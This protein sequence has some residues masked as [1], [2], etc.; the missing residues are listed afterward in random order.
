MNYAEEINAEFAYIGRGRD[1]EQSPSGGTLA[2]AKYDPCYCITTGARWFR[3]DG[4]LL[5][6]L[7]EEGDATPSCPDFLEAVGELLLYT[8]G[9]LEWQRATE[10]C[11]QAE[12]LAEGVEQILARARASSQSRER[13]VELGMCCDDLADALEAYGRK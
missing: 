9:W 11:G 2:A 10:A 6:E 7:G 5:L 3:I 13:L 1:E 8:L 4:R 12:V